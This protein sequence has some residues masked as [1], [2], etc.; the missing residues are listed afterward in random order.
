[1]DNS[2]N[3]YSIIWLVRIKS[4][5]S[6]NDLCTL[7]CSQYVENAFSSNERVVWSYVRHLCARVDDYT[8]FDFE[9]TRKRVYTVLLASGD[10]PRST[11]YGIESFKK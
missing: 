10:G 7:L 11:I 1:M 5:N 4:D 2:N 6:N 3:N 8:K 9:N